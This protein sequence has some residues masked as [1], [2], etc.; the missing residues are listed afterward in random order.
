MTLNIAV[1]VID[2]SAIYRVGL[3]SLLEHA[4]KTQPQIAYADAARLMA[5]DD[6]GHPNAILIGLDWSDQ[7]NRNTLSRLIARFPQSTV[8]V[9][10]EDDRDQAQLGKLNVQH[11]AF[12]V[13][14][15]PLE[16]LS[17]EIRTVVEQNCELN[18]RHRFRRATTGSASRSRRPLSRRENQVLEHLT[19][20]KSNKQI[21]YALNLREKTIK[22]HMTSILTKLGVANRTQAAVHA[23]RVSQIDFRVRENE[24][25][26]TTSAARNWCEIAS[27]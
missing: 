16:E 8:I 23:W 15:I 5:S 11:C 27:E 9:L 13:K 20:G 18:R 12:V 26:T 4:F 6:D 22:N 10:S 3:Q 1:I 2:Q 7:S 25:L 21:A 14:T 24:S 19:Q 17:R